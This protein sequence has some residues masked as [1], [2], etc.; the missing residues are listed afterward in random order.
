LTKTNVP[1]TVGPQKHK[2][3]Q[4]KIFSSFVFNFYLC[5]EYF[6]ESRLSSIVSCGS[7]D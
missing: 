3:N 4:E 5:I 7:F 1:Y 6:T 2:V